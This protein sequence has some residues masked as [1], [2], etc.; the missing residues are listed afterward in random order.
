[1]CLRLHEPT[2]SLIVAVADGVSGAPRSDLAAALAVRHA[3]LA[4]ARQ[5]DDGGVDALD[6]GKV[7]DHA[8]WALLEQHRRDAEDPRAGVEAAARSLATTLTVALVRSEPAEVRVAAVGDSPVLLLSG[9]CFTPIVGQPQDLDGLVGGAVEALPG[10][11]ASRGSAE[12]SFDTGAVL[13]VC[14]DGLALPLGDGS[15]DLGR[16]LVRELASPPDVIDFARLLDFSRATYDDDR[17]LV[18]VWLARE[19]PT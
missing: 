4:L 11:P 18:A 16:A 2:R 6:W 1:M 5:L 3:A 9:D 12:R 10:S 14:T 19:S 17:T 15:G 7:F 13:L 8:A